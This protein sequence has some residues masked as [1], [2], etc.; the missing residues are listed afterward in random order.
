MPH[1]GFETF[2][3]QI[4]RLGPCQRIWVESEMDLLGDPAG[5][6]GNGRLPKREPVIEGVFLGGPS[7]QILITAQQHP[8]RMLSLRA[9]KAV[10]ADQ[11]TENITEAGVAIQWEGTEFAASGEPDLNLG[12]LK[13]LI[14]GTPLIP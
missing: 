7:D 9:G 2:K 8:D 12:I 3:V 5:N 6:A 11:R 4:N 14:H 10:L 1:E 13:C